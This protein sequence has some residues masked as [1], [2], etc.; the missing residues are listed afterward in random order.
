MGAFGGR[1]DIMALFA[2]KESPSITHAGTFNGN[3]LTLAAGIASLE[4]LT[5]EAYERLARLGSRLQHHIQ[6]ISSELGMPFEVNRMVSLVKPDLP[7]A[8]S[9][10]PSVRATAEELRRLLH[11]ALLNRGIKADG[12]LAISTVMTE[13]EL[14]RLTGTLG[15]VLAEFAPAMEALKSVPASTS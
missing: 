10:D 6:G 11:L 14:E 12:N 1:A 9:S 2:D 4:L 13:V 7:Q 3:P 5:E 15:D 8:N